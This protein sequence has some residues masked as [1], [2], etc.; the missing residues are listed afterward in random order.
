MADLGSIGS[1]FSRTN[2]KSHPQPN[3]TS[4]VSAALGAA[5]TLSHT[6]SILDSEHSTDT[7]TEFS[8]VSGTVEPADGRAIGDAE[9]C[10]D[11]SA[12]SASDGS[13]ERC[14]DDSYAFLRAVAPAVRCA[15]T[16]A[17]SCSYGVADC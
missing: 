15:D 10:T 1:A 5:F 17:D 4:S 16:I 3:H 9:R 6:A 7:G 12:Q 13:I 14:S 11:A 2:G 8:S